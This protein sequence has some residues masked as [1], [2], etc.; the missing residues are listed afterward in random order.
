MSLIRITAI[1]AATTILAAAPGTAGP[2]ALSSQQLSSPD[3][4]IVQIRGG[5]AIPAAIIAGVLE[6]SMNNG[7]YLNDCGYGY[8]YGAGGFGYGGGGYGGR[9]GWHGSRGGHGHR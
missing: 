3:W 9:R 5:D 7:C 4:Q 1:A 8:G 6:G 2:V